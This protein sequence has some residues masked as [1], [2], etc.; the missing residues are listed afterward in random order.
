MS[1]ADSPPAPLDHSRWTEIIEAVRTPLGFFVL[2]VLVVEMAL[3]GVVAFSDQDHV[4]VAIKQ[5]LVTGVLGLMF[6]MVVLVPVMSYFPGWIQG[7]RRIADELQG[8]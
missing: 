4:P 1:E 7:R 2:I 5:Q 6:L 3:V 8:R